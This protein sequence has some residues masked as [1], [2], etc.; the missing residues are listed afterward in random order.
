MRKETVLPRGKAQFLHL[1]VNFEFSV[2][3]PNLN[4]DIGIKAQCE[5]IKYYIKW[6]VKNWQHDGDKKHNQHDKERKKH[7]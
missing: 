1:D 3:E 7:F 6:S 4:E 5:H 2:V